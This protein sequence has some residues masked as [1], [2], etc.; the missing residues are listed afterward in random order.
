M[1]CAFYR[2]FHFGFPSWCSIT[3]FCHNFTFHLDVLLQYWSAFYHVITS[4]DFMI[5]L[6]MISFLRIFV[7]I[8][9]RYSLTHVRFD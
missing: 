1:I 3:S 5:L 4:Q 6:V 9:R 2:V 7:A 8:F